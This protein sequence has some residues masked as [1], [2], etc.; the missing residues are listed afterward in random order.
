MT[1]LSL[2]LSARTAPAWWPVD[3][4]M[5]FDFVNDRYM[6][7]GAP[8][9]RSEVLSCASPS[10]RLAEDRAGH[11]HSFAPN[12]PAITNRGLLIQPAATNYAPNAGRPELMS[13]SSPAGINRQ[14]LSTQTIDGLPCASMRFS[15]TALANGEIAINPVEYNAGPGATQG[16][17]WH[18]GVFM[19]LTAGTLPEIARL[20]IFE[21]N[22]SHGLL[23]ASYAA[24]PAS[25]RLTP[26]SVQRSMASPNAAR[27]TSSLRLVVN[28]GQS[29]DF[30]I[31]LGPSH[32]SNGA[33]ADTILTQGTPLLR[34]ADAVRFLLPEDDH[35]LRLWPTGGATTQ[36][37][38]SGNWLLPASSA[39]TIKQA[40]CS[41]N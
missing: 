17:T 7:D 35:V 20:G 28:L 16:Q 8:V 37:V 26:I 34:A 38:A 36:Q 18:A 29:Y 9:A 32:L 27:V 3:A 31:A 6:K 5:A 22:A 15:G 41:A 23:D 13:S 24:L 10:I 25:S 11:W 21:R 30:T 19:A 4:V 2:G 40:W 12:V 33:F 1:K 14:V 39:Y